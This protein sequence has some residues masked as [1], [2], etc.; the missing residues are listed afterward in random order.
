LHPDGPSTEAD[1]RAALRYLIEQRHVQ[2]SDIWIVGR[3]I[4]TG[5]ATQ[6]ATETPH[7]V[8]LILISP[9]TSVSDV[10][11]QL[12]FYRYVFRPVQWLGQRNNFD[13][14][15]KISAAAM[16]VL[17][18]TGTRDQLAAPAMAP[19][20]YDRA[21]EP[22]T[23]HLIPGAGHNDILEVGDGTLVREIQSFIAGNSSQLDH[24]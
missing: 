22:K 16:P 4:G 8:G 10:A 19:I 3:S 23:M 13:N 14:A 7:A 5:V 9:I 6:L 20:L 1:A 12:W 18:I 17:I 2:V 21:K 15:A 24:P 11:N